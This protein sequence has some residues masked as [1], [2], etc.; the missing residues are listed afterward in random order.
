MNIQAQAED[1]PHTR[2]HYVIHIRG[3][4]D[5]RWA[6]WFSRVEISTQEIA[7]NTNITTLDCPAIDQAQLRGILNKIWDLNLS[8]LSVQS[9]DAPRISNNAPD[10]AV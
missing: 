3:A 5:D 8:L 4:L 10:T 6:E 1:N 2:M 7:P 9:A